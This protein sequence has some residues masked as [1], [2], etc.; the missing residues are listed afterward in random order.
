M[1]GI[2]V[3]IRA[4]IGTIGYVVSPFACS[5]I[6]FVNNNSSIPSS[7][8]LLGTL[9]HLTLGVVVNLDVVLVVLLRPLGGILSTVGYLG[10]FLNIGLPL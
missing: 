9:L 2:D 3:Q 5:V 4:C 7:S 8:G 10:I 1:I 6:S